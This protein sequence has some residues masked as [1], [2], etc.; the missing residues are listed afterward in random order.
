MRFA[1]K[2]TSI[3]NTARTARHAVEDA[4]R[5]RPAARFRR[6]ATDSCCPIGHDRSR[7]T[8]PPPPARRLPLTGRPWVRGAVRLPRP[9][10]SRA[11]CVSQLSMA[12]TPR[13]EREYGHTFEDESR[14]VQHPPGSELGRLEN[15]GP[16][17]SRRR[18]S[19]PRTPLDSGCLRAAGRQHD[20]V[21]NIAALLRAGGPDRG[22][23][24][25]EH[26]GPTTR[27]PPGARRPPRSPFVTAS[28]L[29]ARPAANARL[30]TPP[31]LLP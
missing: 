20:P 23:R 26:Y 27:L 31:I 9:A 28:S 11:P 4:R 2:P 13:H 12:S 14:I 15:S 25:I 3:T 16:A 5:E 10:R 24:V 30:A 7:L 19:R 6:A 1:L 21:A 18:P 22:P 17:A 29:H 8:G